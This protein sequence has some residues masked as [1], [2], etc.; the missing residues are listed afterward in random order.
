MS[1][2]KDYTRGWFTASFPLSRLERGEVYY[3]GMEIRQKIRQH[4]TAVLRIRSTRSR[5]FDTF[6]DGAPVKIT[7]TGRDGVT[8]TFIGYVTKVRPV[9]GEGIK[10]RHIRDIVCVAASR[11]L[12]KTDRHTYRNMTAPEIAAKIAQKAGFSLV[13]KQH[14]LRRPTVVHGGETYWE[15][16]TKLA[17]RTG[18]V[19]RVEGTTIYF[20]PLPAMTKAFLSRAPYLSD[21]AIPQEGGWGPRNV[22]SVDMWAGSASD[23]PDNLS[24]DA[25]FTAVEPATGRVHDVSERPGSAVR[26]GR[27]SRS[28]FTR[29]PAGVAAHSRADAKLLAKG[30]ADNGMLAFDTRLTVAGSAALVPY[31]PVLLSVIDHPLSGTMVVK[32][33]THTITTN[34]HYE[35]EVVASTDAMDGSGSTPPRRRATRDTGTELAQGFAP[36]VTA[37][38]RLKVTKVV[39][40]GNPRGTQ[41]KWVAR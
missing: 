13:S 18:Y 34:N 6:Y 29:Y 9:Q 40:G 15:F 30:A 7:Y 32:E 33:V 20:M 37:T 4:D 11:E 28:G 2:I 16:L 31:H 36:D 12:R 26:K 22:F 19:L 35:C 27:T 21:S 8:G 5:W 14:G 3:M 17:K 39:L 25:V 1:T 41:G 23:D 10:G 38:S 24:D